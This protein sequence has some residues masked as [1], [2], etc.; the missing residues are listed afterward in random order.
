[1][2]SSL[3]HAHPQNL[4][5]HIFSFDALQIHHVI[6]SFCLKTLQMKFAWMTF[7]SIKL[8]TVIQLDDVSKIHHASNA[9]SNLTK[10]SALMSAI[11]LAPVK[12][13]AT[14]ISLSINSSRF[15]TPAPPA[16]PNA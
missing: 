6:R 16:A 13:I 11:V 1:M 2:K 3:N 10:Q 8:N 5:N 7:A 15:E 14:R 9:L 12:V 4:L